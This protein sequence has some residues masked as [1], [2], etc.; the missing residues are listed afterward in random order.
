MPISQL[1]IR[2]QQSLC[3]FSMCQTHAVAKNGQIF[4]PTTKPDR[5]IEKIVKRT[6]NEFTQKTYISKLTD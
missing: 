1:K 3:T 2:F 5:D 4:I 6:L